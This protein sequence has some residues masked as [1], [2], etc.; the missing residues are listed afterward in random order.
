MGLLIGEKELRGKGFGT[1]AL[2]TWIKVLF[3]ECG[4]HRIWLE[5]WAMNIPA[6]HCAQ[7][8][9]FTVEGRL[10]EAVLYA[11]E[12]SDVII[13]GILEWE[14]YNRTRVCGGLTAGS[15]RVS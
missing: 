12:W 7:H 13:M 15:A 6:V 14:F 8:C 4:V 5:T 2:S 11:G 9:G 10:R 3:E 1:E